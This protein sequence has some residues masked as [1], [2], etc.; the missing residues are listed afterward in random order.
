MIRMG[1]AKTIKISSK[2]YAELN[3]FTELL[4]DRLK[5]RVSIE[6]ALEDLLSQVQNRRKPS[7]FAGTWV[8]SEEEEEELKE[9]LKALWRTWKKD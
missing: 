9:S 1:E 2:V 4:S 6:D 5:K 8:M 7:D 3:A